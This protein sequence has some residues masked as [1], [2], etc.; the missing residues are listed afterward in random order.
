M[1]LRTLALAAAAHILPWTAAGA[2]DVYQVDPVHSA[3]V[4]RVKHMNASHAWGRFNELSGSFALDP[5][6]PAGSQVDIKIQT[7]SVDTGNAKRDQHLKG[8][9][10][11]NAV[12]F[13]S[14]T[15][16][17][18]SVAKGSDGAYDVTGDLTLHGVTR[19]VRVKVTPVGT[20]KG[21]TGTPVAGVDASFLVKQS[22]FGMTKMVGPI[23][24]EVWVNVSLE[25]GKK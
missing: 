6:D 24:D 1:R 3:V 4:F 12:Q 21:P 5:T 10:F 7:G 18:T 23:G 25:G 16:K 17:S 2:A 11:F 20:A 8:P 22:D 9:D 14:I 19:P 15:F 13:P